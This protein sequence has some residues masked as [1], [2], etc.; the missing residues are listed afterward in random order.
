MVSRAL[1]RRLSNGARD[2]R[3]FIRRQPFDRTNANDRA[4]ERHVRVALGAV[5][6]LLAKLFSVSAGLISVPLTLNYL[7]AE[8]YGMWMTMSS[9]V[10]MF[11]FADLG[12]GNGVLNA[13]ASAYGQDDRGAIRGYVSSGFFGLSVIAAL[14]IVVFAFLYPFV[15]WFRLFN[16]D[17]HEARV[18]AGPAL[19]VLVACFAVAIPTGIVQRVQ[20][21]LQR[22]F[23]AS[24]WQCASSLIGLFGLLLAI[25]FKAGLPWLVFAFAGAPLIAALGNSL[26]FF[27]W[28]EPDIA[29]SIQAV[30]ADAVSRIAQTGLLFFVLQIAAAATLTS[31]NIVIAQTLGAERVTEYAIPER[32][33][34]LIPTILAMVLMPLW[35]AYG[36]AIAR[37]DH[38]W[39]HRILRRSVLTSIGLAAAGSVVL[40][41]AG[42]RLIALW[43]GRSVDPPFLLLL[44]FGLWKVIEAW[45]SAIAALLNGAHIVRAQVV[46]V[47]ITAFVVIT[48]KVLLVASMGTPGAVWSTIIGYS[49]CTAVPYIF[50]IRRLLSTRLA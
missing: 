15:S 19:A 7:G 34:G 30:S 40:V 50:I 10:A 18:E 3:A 46:I 2:I 33:F 6:S 4:R 16:V 13:V 17:A 27:R 41:L 42:P 47:T 28:L 14:I 25:Y 44:G 39:V 20:M 26:L 48:L 11:A 1:L 21:G 49:I 35:P 22:G 38:P 36:E 8:R 12:M 32:M 45:G 31:D 24:L 9:L 37:G 5:A 43:V 23:I 29:P